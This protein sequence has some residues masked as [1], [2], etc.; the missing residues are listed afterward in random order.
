MNELIKFESKKTPEEI[1]EDL[2]NKAIDFDFVIR[3]VF[4][5]NHEFSHHNIK[6]EDEF[7]YYSVMLCNPGKAYKSIT[8]KPIRGALL[9]PPKQVVIYPDK[10]SGK[11]ILAYVKISMEDVKSIMP[12]DKIFQKGLP[13]SCDNIELLMKEVV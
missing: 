1:V 3:E 8:A 10:K 5:M 13:A 9:F 4:D 6:V 12:D 7:K 11:T 2:K